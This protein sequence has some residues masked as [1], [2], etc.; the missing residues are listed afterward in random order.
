MSCAWTLYVTAG[1]N[2][3]DQ[4]I[5]F[6]FCAPAC[7][8]RGAGTGVSV[9]GPDAAVAKAGGCGD[10]VDGQGQYDAA[11]NGAVMQ[12]RCD[13]EI[14]ASTA[15]DANAQLAKILPL[16]WPV[17]NPRPLDKE[18]EIFPGN[19]LPYAGGGGPLDPTKSLN[20]AWDAK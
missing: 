13:Q 12:M 15:A 1:L 10:M 18:T 8:Q 4:L 14:S 20:T 19:S 7:T 6:A 3:Q 9:P 11:N 17:R 5:E 16:L 2:R